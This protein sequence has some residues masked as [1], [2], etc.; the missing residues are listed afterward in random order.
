VPASGAT[1]AET[2]PELFHYTGLQ[3][4]QGILTNQTL[5]A[6]H[7]LNLND[8]TEVIAFRDRLPEILHP[9]VSNGLHKLARRAP[10][11][12]GLIELHGGMEA[13]INEIA[14]AIPTAAFQALLG[15]PSSP[16]YIDPFV[17][18][19][20]TPTTKDIA[21]HGLLSQWRGYGEG[22]TY[23]VVFNTALLDKLLAE[24][25]TTWAGDLFGGD[26]VYSSA[27]AEAV[28]HEFGDY[29]DQICDSL[30]QWFGKPDDEAVLEKVYPALIQCACRYKHWSFFEEK[31]V[32]I[33]AIPMNPE[34]IRELAVRG[35]VVN[36]KP[37]R[38][39]ARKKG[40]KAS[41]I[42]LFERVTCLP[43]KTLPISRI[44]VGP[45]GDRLGR[46]RNVEAL[47]KQVG[48]TIPVTVSAI[49]LA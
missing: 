46:K 19:F 15:T 13:A 28:R 6:V 35:T 24:E 27:S 9:V 31:E 16:P 43:N 10:L 5:W 3:G 33:V 21:E 36:E 26:I 32:R 14:N 4:L 25:A 23:A 37:R 29:L 17:I 8:K 39:L 49:P 22:D 38:E 12:H 1:I 44:I 40:A 47:L 48:L 20:S 7:A 11:N 34:I 2:H 18:S 42:H 30:D 41:C 45:Q